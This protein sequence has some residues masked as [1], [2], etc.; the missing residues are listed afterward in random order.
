MAYLTGTV[1]T[2]SQFVA[3]I[4]NAA[5]SNGW[6]SH[7]FTTL[8]SII[9]SPLGDYFAM[10]LSQGGPDN[11]GGASN[12]IGLGFGFYVYAPTSFNNAF[13]AFQQPGY[14]LNNA[15][16]GHWWRTETTGPYV[17][18]HI[19]ISDG[20]LHAILEYKTKYYA[21]LHLGRLTKLGMAEN[22]G[23]Y[24]QTHNQVNTYTPMSG[25]GY[26]W[27]NYGYGSTLGNQIAAPDVFNIS[28][29][30]TSGVIGSNNVLL[31]SNFEGRAG[32]WAYP[33]AGY[34]DPALS[35][36]SPGFLGLGSGH[37]SGL[38]DVAR[39]LSSNN[40]MTGETLLVPAKVYMRG[41]QNR[42]RFV[43]EVQDTAY[44][45]MSSLE[46]AGQ[47][48][49]GTEEWRVFPLSHFNPNDAGA[50]SSSGTVGIAHKVV[51]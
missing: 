7:R 31:L 6:T 17:S 8:E 30:G 48:F 24:V 10:R 38:P 23:Q 9:Q 32:R 16:A 3:A 41:A 27:T 43:G 21:H 37:M 33:P 42:I 19:F 4:H 47:F 28:S 18:Y 49:L 50:N 20:Y 12:S 26:P 29:F 45:D 1:S 25:S 15:A 22:G 39:L 51:L 11:T 2:I 46:P 44:C 13:S 40:E 35:V 14:F 36:N 34:F 5:V